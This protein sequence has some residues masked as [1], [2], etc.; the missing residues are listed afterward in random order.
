MKKIHVEART[1]Q[2]L[3][4]NK[5]LPVRMHYVYLLENGR[6]TFLCKQRWYYGTEQY[7]FRDLPLNAIHRHKW[8]RDKMVDNLM[9]KLPKYLSDA[10]RYAAEYAA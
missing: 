3:K 9:N 10:E 6:K 7:F 2:H 5:R 4:N 8:G 1:E